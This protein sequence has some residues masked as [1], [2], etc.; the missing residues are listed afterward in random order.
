MSAEAVLARLDGAKQT[1]PGRWIAKCPGHEDKSPSLSIRELD[2]GRVLLHDFGGCGALEVLDSLGLDWAALFPA[3]GMPGSAPHH[4]RV[5]AAD[6]LEIADHEIA[7][8]ALILA[9]IL[10]HRTVTEDQWRRLATAA[11]RIGRLRD[12]DR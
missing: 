6:R 4:A 9:D 2:D 5:S 8:A 1:G 12:H 3:S 7:V 10:D 11:A